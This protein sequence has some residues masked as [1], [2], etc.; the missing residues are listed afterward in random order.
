MRARPGA[1]E[2]EAERDR[3]TREVAD[4]RRRAEEAERRE[5]AARQEADRMKSVATRAL[6]ALRARG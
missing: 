6:A 5:R 2:R 1:R 4:Q 3:L